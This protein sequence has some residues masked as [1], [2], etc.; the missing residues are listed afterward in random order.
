MFFAALHRKCPKEKPILERKS[1]SEKIKQKSVKKWR[2]NGFKNSG[3]KSN[4]K[5]LFLIETLNVF[6]S[7]L[8]FVICFS[9]YELPNLIDMN[10]LTL[11][12]IWQSYYFHYFYTQT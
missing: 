5:L 7:N 1:E 9:K 6:K 3:V 12:F 4:T 2:I 8:V 11:K 10:Q